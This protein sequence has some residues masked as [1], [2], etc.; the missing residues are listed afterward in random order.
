M[1]N[2]KVSYEKARKIMRLFALD[3]NQSLNM[4]ALLTT[5]AKLARR[6][7]GRISYYLC[8]YAADNSDI[9]SILETV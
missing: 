1:K 3:K 5:G 6:D 7:S 2:V 4:P 8:G 9:N